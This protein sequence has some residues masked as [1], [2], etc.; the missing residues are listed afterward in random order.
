MLFF[1]GGGNMASF[2]LNILHSTR[3]ASTEVINVFFKNWV[4][5][6]FMSSTSAYPWTDIGYPPGYLDSIC[7]YPEKFRGCGKSFC[8]M[9]QWRNLPT[10]ISSSMPWSTRCNKSYLWGSLIIFP[11][12]LNLC[13]RVENGWKKKEPISF[14][15]LSGVI[16]SRTEG[17]QTPPPSKII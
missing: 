8:Q 1:N 9:F 14:A 4:L 6:D 5:S 16:E 2:E 13:G 12:Y 7:S 11:R 15:A 10:T 3:H 17:V